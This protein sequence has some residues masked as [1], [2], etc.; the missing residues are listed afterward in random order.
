MVS[1][2][3]NNV[4]NCISQGDL[5]NYDISN[6]SVI[7]MFVDQNTNNF[8]KQKFL[9]LPK[10]TKII[11]YMFNFDNWEPTYTH[12]IDNIPLYIWIV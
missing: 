5:I 7:Y 12:I 9:S 1:E 10:G 2:A 3:K 6:A 4:G 11:S 8:M